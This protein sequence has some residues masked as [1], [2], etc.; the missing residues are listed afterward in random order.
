M[1]GRLAELLAQ[2]RQSVQQAE[3]HTRVLLQLQAQ[4]TRAQ[5]VEARTLALHDLAANAAVLAERLGVISG[6]GLADAWARYGAGDITVFVRSFLGFAVSHP[7][8]AER[9]AEAVARDTLARAALAAFVRR[10]EQLALV[11]ADDKMIREILEEGA[12]G[13]SYRLFK[14][15]DERASAPP[16]AVE[17]GPDDLRGDT[18]TGEESAD[19]RLAG[20]AQR[21]EAAAPGESSR[22]Q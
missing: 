16:K 15:A 22:A 14:E 17:A 20:L 9:M 11:P 8:I 6:Q 19:A 4:S 10:Y 18:F 21:L 7:D 13:R 3:V 1:V 5:G 12:L 2:G